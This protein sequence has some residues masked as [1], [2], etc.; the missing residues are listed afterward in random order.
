M[1]GAAGRLVGHF[2]ILNGDDSAVRLRTWLSSST[3][4]LSSIQAGEENGSSLAGPL[5]LLG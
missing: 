3:A 1:I 4:R 2:Y 5:F